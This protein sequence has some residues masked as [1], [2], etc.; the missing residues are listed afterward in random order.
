MGQAEDE[1]NS[2]KKWQPRDGKTDLAMTNTIPL[3]TRL[4]RV[5]C[6]FDVTPVCLTEIASCIE[7]SFTRRREARLS[8]A[9][10]FL[11]ASPLSQKL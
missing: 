4:A 7:K 3:Q 1:R 9:V 10:Y 2:E 8:P 5:Y 11:S 6:I